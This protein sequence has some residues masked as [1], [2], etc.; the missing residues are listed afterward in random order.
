MTLAAPLLLWAVTGVASAAPAMIS[1]AVDPLATHCGWKLGAAATRINLP[2]EVYDGGLKR[3]NIDLLQFAPTPP[4]NTRT[5]RVDV[6]AL[7]LG[8]GNESGPS[9]HR[10][11]RV[12]STATTLRY[13]IIQSTAC[14]KAAPIVCFPF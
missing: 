12:T 14:T 7:T 10:Y 1:D 4:A 6:T 2:V 9:N 13:D 3:C 8:A 11:V 5:T